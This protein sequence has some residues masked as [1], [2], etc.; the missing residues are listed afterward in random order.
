MYKR[1]GSL[2]KISPDK[3]LISIMVHAMS[4]REWAA[5]ALCWAMV[6]FSLVV[7]SSVTLQGIIASTQF[8]IMLTAFPRTFIAI[9]GKCKRA[10]DRWIMDAAEMK[11]AD[12]E[13]LEMRLASDWHRVRIPMQR[14]EVRERMVE[15]RLIFS[16][17]QR[18]H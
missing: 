4:K 3:I 12:L 10:L 13:I 2:S 7:K 6:V 16:S 14:Q 18:N 8:I 15:A 9:R 11:Y 17:K 5:F 1:A